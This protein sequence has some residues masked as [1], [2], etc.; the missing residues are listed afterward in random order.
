MFKTVILLILICIFQLISA[1]D[2]CS[3]C[4][5]LVLTSYIENGEIEKAQS[6]SR[7]TPSIG[8]V[9]SYS[10]FFN[11]NKTCGNHLFFWFFPAEN[12]WKNAPVILWL[13]GG[14]GASSMF[15]M[16]E[17]IGPFNSFPEGLQ[18]RNY[19]WTNLSNVLFI[20]NPVG[21]GF[22]YTSKECYP[23]SISVVVE[24]L[25]SALTQFFKLFPTLVKNDFYL[26]GESFAGHYIPPLAV[27]IDK[28]NTEENKT[29]INLKGIIIGNPLMKL[30]CHDYGSFLYGVGIAGEKL[31]D[32]LYEYQSRLKE[33]VAEKNYT[34]ANL[35]WYY[36]LNDLINN[37]TQLPNR[38]NILSETPDLSNYIDYLNTSAVRAQIHVG[39]QE[40]F[41]TNWMTYN[42][43][44]DTIAEPF[45]SDV[46]ILLNTTKYV[47]VMY[48]GN[49]D[50]ICMYTSTLCI[51]N[52]LQWHGRKEYQNAT[53]NMWYIRDKVVGYFK[54]ADNRLCDIVIKDSGH[55]VPYYKPEESYEMM[56]S[57][58]SAKEGQNPLWS[59][60]ITDE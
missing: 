17:L 1:E 59:F 45:T 50:M 53:R 28:M 48:S 8:N 49:L 60:K 21:A 6:L 14:P 42:N 23:R 37:Q 29:N 36:I 20:D 40:Y 52:G 31:R 9:T 22:S 15:G 44:T 55:S 34:A 16:F 56:K 25:L 11:T 26:T 57:I 30:D 4:S 2:E 13:Q 39:Q 12:D 41:D 32:Q 35:D 19:S 5:P 46:E 27:A 18:R 54:T 51:L 47:V 58:L 43:L 10:G 33:H 24:D 7:V 3:T 38:T